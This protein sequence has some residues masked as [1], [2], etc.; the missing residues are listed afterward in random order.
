MSDINEYLNDV[1]EEIETS[2][3]DSR[4]NAIEN[5]MLNLRGKIRNL[6]IKTESKQ[7]QTQEE[8]QP[9]YDKLSLADA[10]VDIY[11]NNIQEKKE[12]V[13]SPIT[14]AGRVETKARIQSMMGA[15]SGAGDVGKVSPVPP[16]HAGK[17]G[18]TKGFGTASVVIPPLS[19]EEYKEQIFASFGLI[20]QEE[21]FE[22]IQEEVI[23]EEYD[24]VSELEDVLLE[25]EDTS[26]QG[27]DKAMRKLCRENDMTPKELHK[28]FK[29]K[30]GMIPDE[31]IKEQQVTE[32]CGWIPLDEV[33]RVNKVGQVYDVTFIFRGGTS[34][35]K[36]FWPEAK[37]PSKADMQAAVEK[38]YPK[39]KL[40]TYYPSMSGNE[41]NFMVMVPPMTEDYEIIPEDTWIEMPEELNE[42]YHQ[43]CE[44]VGEPITF[45][46]DNDDENIV[47]YVEDHDTGEEQEVIIEG[48]LHA[49]FSKSKS[50][51]GKGGWVQS[52][53]STCARKPGQ[54]S[55]PKCYSSQRLAALKRTPEG[56]KKIRSADA[57]KKS[58]D[59]GQSSKTGAAKPTMVKTFTDPKDKKR[60]KSGD[61]TLKDESF[62]PTIDEAC[63]AGYTQKGMKTMFG[64]QYPNCVKKG[65]AKTKKEEVEYVAEG[66][67][68]S[69]HKRP[70]DQGAGLTQK[71]VDAENRKTGGNLQ[72][73]VT[74]PP[75]KLKPGSKAAG[76]RKSFCARS[77]GWNG[78]RGKAAR[79]R[80]NC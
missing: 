67:I 1:K 76:R 69:G 20:E 59:S 2:S 37:R 27:I 26:W 38:L 45:P 47:L 44:E 72:T 48:G 12:K 25:L 41:N 75:S 39:G 79:R 29:S 33:T 18:N 56:K 32:E 14:K 36:F 74:T 23:T 63:W 11:R 16:E 9:R 21:V 13:S 50:K 73:A 34:R 61:Q 7:Q 70:T 43:I 58:Q 66:G 46:M 65:K 71:G 31:W 30:H 54:T 35:V 57:R 22:E 80:W 40:V 15:G 28:E 42:I 53:G 77:R 3:S 52:D 64:K 49:W 62:D 51:D 78:E 55:A 24:V 10:A 17:S 60:Y 6:D 68:K 8:T 19:M 5:G 4:V